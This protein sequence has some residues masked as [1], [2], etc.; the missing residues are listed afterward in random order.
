M[1]VRSVPESSMVASRGPATSAGTLGAWGAT[2]HSG[3]QSGGWQYNSPATGSPFG[4]G[5]FAGRGPRNDQRSD[6]RIREDVNERLTADPG[7]DASD[8]DVR[9]QSGEGGRAGTRP[10]ASAC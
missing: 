5:S 7:I 1:T 9:V 2:Q 6:D 3:S 4:A 8:V 10:S